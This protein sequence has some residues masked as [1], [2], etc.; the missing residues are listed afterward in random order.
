A[1]AREKKLKNLQHD[2]LSSVT[3]EFKTPLTSIIGYADL[4]NKYGEDEELVNKGIRTIRKQSERLYRL[5]EKVLYLS[6]I[7]KY[8]FEPE[9]ETFPVNDLIRESMAGIRIKANNRGILI[10]TDLQYGGELE[11][12]FNLLY[13]M[14][15]NILD[16]AIKYNVEG[17]QVEIIT[18]KKDEWLK[19]TVRDSGI[20]IDPEHLER[21]FEPFYREE[22]DRARTTGGDG[23]GL[24]IV[25]EITEA[26]QG[27]IEIKSHQGLG[28]EVVVWLPLKQ[29]LEDLS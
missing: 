21:I 3:H 25:K 10:R 27:K 23:L 6:S 12:D 29:N 7:D 28:T 5:V 11:G 1:L 18:E 14:M 20:S 4:L 22:K 9:L 17:G 13:R 16:N 15:I 26:H 19:L 24:S 2:F 8:N